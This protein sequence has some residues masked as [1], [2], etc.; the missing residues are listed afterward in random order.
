MQYFVGA[1]DQSAA[2][3]A[4]NRSDH[5]QPAASKHAVAVASTLGYAVDAAAGGDY[6]DALAWLATVESIGD[7]LPQEYETK[8]VAWRLAARPRT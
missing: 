6:V 1:R 5:Y 3:P 4:S 7:V 8:R 2:R